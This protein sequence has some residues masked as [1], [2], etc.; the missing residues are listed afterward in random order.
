FE[1][2]PLEFI[3]SYQERFNV[4][5]QLGLPRFCGGLAGY[6][7]YDTIRHIE[8][9]LAGVDKPDPLGTPD[10][11]LQLTEKLPVIDNLS[12]KIYL[13]VYADPRQSDAFMFAQRRLRELR[14]K[15]REPVD[16]PYSRASMLTPTSTEFEHDK[17]IAAVLRAKEYIMAGDMMQVQI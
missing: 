3:A 14:M 16:I 17:Y 8:K 12:G 15:L 5:P 10:N 4:A 13:I 7:G 9:K 11:L 2:N 1:G 6:F